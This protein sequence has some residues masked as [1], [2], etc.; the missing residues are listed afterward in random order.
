MPRIKKTAPTPETTKDYLTGN[1]AVNAD[2]Y[3]I[4]EYGIP[5][6][7]PVRGESPLMDAYRDFTASSYVDHLIELYRQRSAVIRDIRVD[8]RYDSREVTVTFSVLRGF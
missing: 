6:L 2:N 7:N 3:R 8:S 4:R 1:G 5:N